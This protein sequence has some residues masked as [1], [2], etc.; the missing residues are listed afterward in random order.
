MNRDNKV[1]L[2]AAI[3][4]LVGNCLLFLNNS[5]TIG[6]LQFFVAA[7]LPLLLVLP[8][9]FIAILS[10]SILRG[11]TPVGKWGPEQARAI[12]Q[13]GGNVFRRLLARSFLIVYIPILLLGG[14]V[15]GSI[16]F[17]FSLHEIFKII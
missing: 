3:F 15:T 7:E 11:T 16:I 6:K 8:L 2:C 5:K 4:S 14:W 9:A 1:I 12:M 17:Y 13:T 10:R